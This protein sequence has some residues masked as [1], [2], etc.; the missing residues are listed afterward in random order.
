MMGMDVELGGRVGLAVVRL[1]VLRGLVG[2]AGLGT[3]PRGGCVL[4]WAVPK[5]GLRV[6]GQPWAEGRNPV[7]IGR[8]EGSEKCEV[9]S[10]N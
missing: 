6:S 4:V 8:G 2:W 1:P 5:V 10:V 9:R 7:G 3:Q